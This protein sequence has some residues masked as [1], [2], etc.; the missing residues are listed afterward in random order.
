MAYTRWR[1]SALLASE[2][3]GSVSTAA[4]TL[5]ARLLKQQGPPLQTA[6]LRQ[7]AVNGGAQLT[8]SHKQ[9]RQVRGTPAAVA[10][11]QPLDTGRRV[12]LVPGGAAVHRAAMRSMHQA[13]LGRMSA[14]G[15]CCP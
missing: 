12:H 7:W 5:G 9:W 3:F 10:A 2:L 8:P 1:T 11:D 15:S 4:G 13:T 14:S 6:E